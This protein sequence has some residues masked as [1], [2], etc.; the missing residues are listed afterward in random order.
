MF[1]QGAYRQQYALDKKYDNSTRIT[2]EFIGLKIRMPAFVITG[3]AYEIQPIDVKFSGSAENPLKAASSVGGTSELR[4]ATFEPDLKREQIS[5]TEP[6]EHPFALTV[7][8]SHNFFAYDTRI[9]TGLLRFEKMLGT[10]WSWYLDFGYAGSRSTDGRYRDSAHGLGGEVGMNIYTRRRA[11]EGLYFGGGLGYWDLKGSWTDDAGT[12]FETTGTG[13]ARLSDINV[14]LGYKWA[15]AG[16]GGFFIDSSIALDAM[17][18]R[19]EPYP[20]GPAGGS[21]KAG[22]AIG[23]RW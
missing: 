4:E 15:F 9:S 19:C 22:L 2:V 14:H 16:S 13:K 10:S 5:S 8:V 12:P 6:E 23:K 21:L 3:A 20:F 17:S 1:S 18:T 11:L 7:G